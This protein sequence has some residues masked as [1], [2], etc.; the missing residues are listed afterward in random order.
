[1]DSVADWLATL[2]ENYKVRG[3]SELE[4]PNLIPMPSHTDLQ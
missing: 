1:M 4:W 3:G 2:M